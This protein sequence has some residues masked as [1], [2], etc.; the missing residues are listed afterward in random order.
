MGDTM[1]QAFCTRCGASLTAG[2]RF[3]AACGTPI[4]VGG[5]SSESY[6]QPSGLPDA[7]V[8]PPTASPPATPFAPPA[9]TP[10]A[11]IP[12]RPLGFGQKIL[13]GLFLIVFALVSIVVVEANVRARHPHYHHY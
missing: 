9:A 6:S 8:T 4:Q 2:T 7:G 3:C 1:S 12:K 13:L 11:P 10:Y 5:A